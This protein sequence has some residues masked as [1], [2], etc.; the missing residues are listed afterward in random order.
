MRFDKEMIY[1]E[2]RN[3]VPGIY[4]LRILSTD[5]FNT[6]LSAY[7]D[8]DEPDAVIDQMLN[9][10]Y[11]PNCNV[12]LYLTSNPVKE[13]CRS[14]EQFNNLRKA[15]VMTTDDDIESLTW[16]ALDVDPIHPAGTSATDDEVAEAKKQAMAV[17]KHMA[18]EGFTNP[19][20]V[21]SGNGYHLKY[22]IDYP[23]DT[24]HR[25]KLAGVID[26]LHARFPLIDQA[27]K[28]PS[29]ILKLPGTLAMKGRDTEERPHRMSYIIRDPGPIGTEASE[30]G[31]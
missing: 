1:R 7:F 8:R 20:I 22:R 28:N 24:E 21:F 2:I 27:A 26:S 23:N 16:L 4:E 3:K 12:N 10:R 9:W 19:E 13:Y 25:I 30:H 17:Y 6:K 31:K 29:R 18:A 15:K 14:R 11:P 5:F